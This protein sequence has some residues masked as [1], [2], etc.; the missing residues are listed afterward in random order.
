[1]G[2]FKEI[3]IN[4]DKQLLDKAKNND[5]SIND[6]FVNSAIARKVNELVDKKIKYEE[7]K[8]RL[9]LLEEQTLFNIIENCIKNCSKFD[10]ASKIIIIDEAEQDY[11]F[12]IKD[13]ITKTLQRLEEKELIYEY[14]K[15]N[16]SIVRT[17]R[18]T[19]G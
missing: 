17:N 19:L 11:I 5:I 12:F 10:Y 18:I 4:V 6:E 15:G 2:K 3:K 9:E 13:D 1:M 16:Y 14:P 7:N 8:K